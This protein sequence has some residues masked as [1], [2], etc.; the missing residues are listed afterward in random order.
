[1][2]ESKLKDEEV[3]CTSCLEVLK[4]TMKFIVKCLEVDAILTKEKEE[5]QG[6]EGSIGINSP[7]F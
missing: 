6:V 3:V 1:M 7:F 5:M 2:Q 4:S